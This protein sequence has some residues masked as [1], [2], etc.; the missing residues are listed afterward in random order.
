M[1]DLRHPGLVRLIEARRQDENAFFVS[2]YVPDGNFEQFVSKEGQPLLAP[3]E[4]A[5]L[6]ADA[7]DGLGFL[8]TRGYVHRDIKPRNILIRKTNG[9]MM[10][11]L[12]DFGL[13][14][15]YERHGGT[16]TKSGECAGTFMY[17][18]PEQLLSF[19]ESRP[20][21]DVY[22]MGITLYY[23][24]TAS[25]P[26]DF[27]APHELKQGK[28]LLRGCLRNRTKSLSFAVGAPSGR[29][30]G[31]R[32]GIAPGGRSYKAKPR[33]LKQALRDPVRMI[34]EDPPRPTHERRPDLS[35]A[36]CSVIDRAIAKESG[37]R[38]PSV[39]EFQTALLRAIG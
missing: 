27:P 38:Y 31:R 20:T 7:L 12:A 22:A 28:R 26:L 14:R 1:E 23:V 21:V 17:M 33:I 30:T 10:P 19:K 4:A 3:V 2:E 35:T 34:L 32:I 16:I 13:A 15:S 9:G 8:H 11:K 29:D 36:L 25:Y 5:R 39:Q 6:I 24:L 37:E 18:P